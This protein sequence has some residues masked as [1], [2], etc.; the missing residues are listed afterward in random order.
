MFEAPE[1][2]IDTGLLGA[3]IRHERQSQGYTTAE[4]FAAAITTMT[5]YKVSKETIYK[6]ES[7][8][9]EP[10]LSLFIAIKFLLFTSDFDVALPRYWRESIESHHDGSVDYY[11]DGTSVSNIPSI[12]QQNASEHISAKEDGR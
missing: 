3:L 2:S 7:G 12:A 6:V 1:S 9:Q 10:K 5:G 8:K 11:P 4:E